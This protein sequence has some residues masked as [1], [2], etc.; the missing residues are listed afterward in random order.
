MEAVYPRAWRHARRISGT[1][2]VGVDFDLTSDM[3]LALRAR[4]E[5]KRKSERRE[6]QEREHRL[7]LSLYWRD[8][9]HAHVA[10]V[11]LT[12]AQDRWAPGPAPVFMV[13]FAGRRR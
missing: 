8:K 5:K 2:R 4:A 1:L 7:A 13:A 6:D 11:M 3:K 10:W 9:L 12:R